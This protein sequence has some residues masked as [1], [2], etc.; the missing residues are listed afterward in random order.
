MELITRNG[1]HLQIQFK[2]LVKKVIFMEIILYYYNSQYLLSKFTQIWPGF[3]QRRAGNPGG[4][5][6]RGGVKHPAA[7]PNSRKKCLAL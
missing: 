7:P 5:G 6:G 3:K 4:G 1:T 2:E